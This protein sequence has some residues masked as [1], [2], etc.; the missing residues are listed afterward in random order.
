MT[1]IGAS[2]YRIEVVWNREFDWSGYGKPYDTPEQA[3]EAAKD[4][5]NS[6]DGARVK[7]AQVL[8]EEGQVVFRA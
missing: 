6:G 7:K 5:V 8:D 4:V 2:M 3:I 1:G